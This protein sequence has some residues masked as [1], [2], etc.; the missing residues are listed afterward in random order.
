MS[1]NAWNNDT[2]SSAASPAGSSKPNWEQSVIERMVMSSVTEQRRSRR[3]GIFFKS[4]FLA[5]LI[6]ILFVT[7][8]GDDDS[9]GGLN[10]PHVAM[11]KIEGVIDAQRPAN[12]ADIIDGLERAFK[13]KN[14][15]AIILNINSPGGSAVQAGEVYDEIMRLRKENPEKK[16]YAVIS[17]AGASGAYY[18]AAA[19]DKIYANKASIVGSIGVLMDGF[20]FVDTMKKVGVERRLVTSGEHKGWLDPFSPVNL[21]D[22]DYLKEMLDTVHTQFIDSVKAGR[23]DRLKESPELFSGLAWSG[24]QAVGMGLVDGLGSINSV[25]RDEFKT[26]NIVDYSHKDNFLDRLSSQFGAS[27]AQQITGYMGGEPGVKAV[28]R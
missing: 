9:T 15:T 26:D 23:G 14:A 17:D 16:V 27:F 5:Y 8:S 7:F 13:E 22:V 19:S 6:F 20:G 24:E 28:V 25:A 21:Q 11:I 4:A 1:D 10:E 2:T 12:A 3:W 18:I